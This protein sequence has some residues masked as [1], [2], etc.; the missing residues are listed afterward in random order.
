MIAGKNDL[1]ASI[2]DARWTLSQVQN[3]VIEYKEIE[4]GHE[5]FIIGKD[6]TFFTEDV[7]L[8]LQ[9]YHPVVSRNLY[10]LPSDNSTWISK[11][12]RLL[13]SSGLAQFFQRNPNR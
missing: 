3:T 10:D 6:M 5:S 12:R 4:G 1:L 11:G 8:K 2:E 9:Q 7:M 13:Q